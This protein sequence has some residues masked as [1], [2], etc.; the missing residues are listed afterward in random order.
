MPRFI[1][2]LR[3]TVSMVDT[4]LHNIVTKDFI[5]LSR[6]SKSSSGVVVAIKKGNRVRYA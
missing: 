6:S 5:S 3:Y 4:Q 2:I 1:F